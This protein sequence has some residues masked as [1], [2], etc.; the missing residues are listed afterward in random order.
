MQNNKFVILE[1]DAY[2]LAKTSFCLSLISFVFAIAVLIMQIIINYNLKKSNFR[3]EQYIKESILSQ[4][5]SLHFNC[6][7][8]YKKL[9][10]TRK[11]LRSRSGDYKGKF[12][13]D[14]KQTLDFL[15]EDVDG[16]LKSISNLI[17]TH[18]NY[19]HDDFITIAKDLIAEYYNTMDVFRRKSLIE[20][21]FEIWEKEDSLKLKKTLDKLRSSN[22][23]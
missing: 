10:A 14:E 2:E 23:Y 4:L 22:K 13:E 9:E 7:Y 21:N 5:N 19:L 11:N 8:Y 1:H 20:G 3:Y 18:S 17:T 16:S 15:Y 12:T 6:G